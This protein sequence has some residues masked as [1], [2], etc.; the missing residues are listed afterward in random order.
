VE[1]TVQQSYAVSSGCFYFAAPPG[2][3]F[4]DASARIIGRE[5]FISMK[6]FTDGQQEI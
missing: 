2:F 3:P 6:G 1:L 4:R 5:D